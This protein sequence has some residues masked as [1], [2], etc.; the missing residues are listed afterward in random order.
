MKTPE[1]LIKDF[2]QLQDKLEETLTAS[3]ALSSEL[4]KVRYNYFGVSDVLT[5]VYTVCKLLDISVDRL[6]QANPHSISKN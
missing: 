5:E 1:E 2:E 4:N 3:H 6:K